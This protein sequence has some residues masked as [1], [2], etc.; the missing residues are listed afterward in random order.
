MARLVLYSG[1]LVKAV[2]RY[3]Q[4][5]RSK[6]RPPSRETPRASRRYR[7]IAH[8]E[9]LQVDQL[10][11]IITA[12]FIQECVRQ[13]VK[14]IAVGDLGGIREDRPR[15]PDEP[16][17]AR[18]AV[19]Q[20]GGMLRYKGASAGIVVRA[21][22]EERGTSRTCHCCG[23]ERPASRV[24]RGLY[25]CPCGWTCQA[26]ANASLKIFERAYRVSPV[27]GSSGR[28]ARPVVLSF[29]AGWHTVHEPKRNLRAS[30]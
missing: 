10:L 17:F 19:P 12:H 21:D 11:H 9:R 26:D 7:Q 4:K 8:R 22:T 13:V 23:R 14:E 2:R 6:V 24:H 15:F 29:R 28:V 3:W 20:T 30:A 25:R 27:K 1:R 5:V 18:L 16:T